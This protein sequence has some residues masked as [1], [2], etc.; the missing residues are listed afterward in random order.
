M[1]QFNHKIIG[2]N[3]FR[4]ITVYRHMIGLVYKVHLGFKVHNSS[5]T[6][7]WFIVVM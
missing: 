4:F 2:Q 6:Y 7:D 1:I 5:W 3:T